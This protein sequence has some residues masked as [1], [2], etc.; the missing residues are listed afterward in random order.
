VGTKEDVMRVIERRIHVDAT[1]ETVWAV[2]VDVG[3]Y[4]AW[5]PFITSVRGEPTVGRRLEVRIAPPGG[6]AMALRPVVTAVRPLHHFA[7]VG[8][9]AHRVVFEG[10]HEFELVADADGRGCTFVQRETFRGFLVPF[11]RR[12]LERTAVGFDLMNR[13]LR[14]RAEEAAVRS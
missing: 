13:A 12:T 8:R 14:E 6:R 10:A 4:G 5:N 3:A 7:W 11:V 1:P 2:L 9:L